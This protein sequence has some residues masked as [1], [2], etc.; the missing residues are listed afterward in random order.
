MPPRQEM[1]GHHHLVQ[2]Q[3]LGPH[4]VLDQIPRTELLRQA[5]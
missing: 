3:F 4:C 1:M 5:L 2:T